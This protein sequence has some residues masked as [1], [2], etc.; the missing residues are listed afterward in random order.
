MNADEQQ[1]THI[2]STSSTPGSVSTDVTGKISVTV[3][4][5]VKY[6][7]MTGIR[8]VGGMFEFFESWFV[9]YLGGRPVM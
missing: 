2:A 5:L 7:L 1:A 8:L 3:M 4:K 9:Q 6:A